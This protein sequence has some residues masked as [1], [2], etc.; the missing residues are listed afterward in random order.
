MYAFT[1]MG[2]SISKR[3]KKTNSNTMDLGVHSL[4]DNS[5]SN[6][7]QIYYFL[8]RGISTEDICREKNINMYELLNFMIINNIDVTKH[9]Y[10]STK[11]PIDIDT[12]SN[13]DDM[14]TKVEPF[15]EE[16]VSSKTEENS[17][18]LTKKVK[19]E[20]KESWKSHNFP[21]IQLNGMKYFCADCN[22]YNKSYHCSCKRKC[23]RWCCVCKRYKSN[24]HS[25]FRVNTPKKRRRP[26]TDTDFPVYREDDNT[27]YCADCKK[28]NKNRLCSC[29]RDCWKWCDACLNYKSKHHFN[30]INHNK[31]KKRKIK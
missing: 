28:T 7:Q 26:W 9:A 21:T 11:T 22:K 29:S 3:K 15:T 8:T 27:Y 17:K 16:Q 19:K 14:S 18:C 13:G 30:V 6:K 25:H 23:W 10:Q 24:H 20:R 31:R 1:K 5:E 12:S 2:G 4:F